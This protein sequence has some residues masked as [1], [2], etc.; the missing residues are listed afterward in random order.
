M[1]P[2]APSN[3]TKASE[4]AYA[5]AVVQYATAMEDWRRTTD[6]DV[7]YHGKRFIG[8]FS[9]S[10]TQQF[11]GNCVIPLTLRMDPRYIPTSTNHSAGMRIQNAIAQIAVSR[12]N[13][14]GRMVNLPLI[15]GT[16]GAAFIAQHLYYDQLGVPELATNRLAAKTVGFNLA[17]DLL[18]NIVHE[19]LPHR[20]S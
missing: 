9:E 8:G 4:I 20:E 12:T 15:G 19:F 1:Y 7:R 2:T 3:N 18:L 11:L 13:S 5:E 17:A 6:E 16:L 10:E 14:G